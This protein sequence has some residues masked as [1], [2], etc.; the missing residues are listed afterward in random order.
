MADDYK[1][2]IGAEV[3]ES[4]FQAVEARVANLTQQKRTIPLVIDPQ[5][6][7]ELGQIKSALDTIGK[8]SA[9]LNLGLN[10]NEIA[11]AKKGIVG[12]GNSIEDIAKASKLL[13]DA[14]TINSFVEAL[15][16]LSKGSQIGTEIK[17]LTTEFEKIRVAI[18]NTQSAISTLGANGSLQGMA[19]A[20]NNVSDSLR[21][22][23]TD[24]NIVKTTMQNLSGSD[25]SNFAS[26]L[27]QVD[28]ETRALGEHESHIRE[29][30]DGI[31][32][33]KN[34]IDTVVNGLK[35]LN[36]EIEKITTKTQGNHRFAIT[37]D[38][39][40]KDGTKVQKTINYRQTYDRKNKAYTN[41]WVP[42]ES[43]KTVQSFGVKTKTVNESKKA[44]SDILHALS[45]IGRIRVELVS[46]TDPQR[47]EELT[48]D[49]KKYRA[50][51][52]DIWKMVDAKNLFGDEEEKQ[53]SRAA[54]STADKIN[55]ANAKKRT[56]E[57]GQA[58]AVRESINLWQ[59]DADDAS[60]TQKASQV[61]A[62]T[63]I[64]AKAIE[65]YRVALENLRAVKDNANLNDQQVIETQNAY[66]NALEKVNNVLS[67]QINLEKA[68]KPSEKSS[69]EQRRLKISKDNFESGMNLW[70]SKNS[71]AAEYY[72]AEIQVIREELK[73]CDSSLELAEVNS[74]FTSLK[75]KAQEAG[76]T[77]RSFGESLKD[78]GKKFV[79]AFSLERIVD[80]AISKL[81]EMYTQVVEIDSALTDFY[82]VTDEIPSA[83]EAYLKNAKKDAHELGRTV[84]SYIT[85][86]ATWAQRGYSMSESESLAKVS[87][88]YANVGDV[89]DST[90]VGDLTA[91][92][93]AFNIEASNAIGI[94]DVL[95]EVSNNFAVSAADL[96]TG[97]S[98]SASTMKTANTSFEQTAAL[99]TGISE[100]TQSPS[101]AGNFLRTA[102]MRIRGMKGELE[103]LGETVD[104]DVDSI[105]KVQT[106]ILNLTGGKVNI[107]DDSGN[108][109]NYYDIMR[110]IAEVYNSL[111]ATNQASLSEI[112]FG[113][114]RSN[115]GAALIQ[116]FQSGQ[117]DKAYETALQSEGSAYAEQ[118]K[119]AESLQYR[120]DK[121]ASSWQALSD[122]FLDSGML[123]TALDLI[124]GIL[125]CVNGIISGVGTLPATLTTIAGILA[126]KGVGERIK[127]FHDPITLGNEYA[128]KTFY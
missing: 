88:I 67:A 22:I 64:I 35:Q 121:I 116:A 4:E 43:E 119:Y 54:E 61:K 96:G 44:L 69:A 106:Q 5:T 113:K 48:Q 62:T 13:G 89:D 73:K 60:V 17:S 72:A 79:A 117:I 127:Q 16:N 85:Q 99:L 42:E 33:G 3:K 87:S 46:E 38:G 118:E 104:D 102:S 110:E 57:A 80:F 90:A 56:Q 97:F 29:S 93:K 12:L 49:L 23:V 47:I 66:A 40:D 21:Q 125:Q 26:R 14:N 98:N 108:F 123:K 58:N 77:V 41:N 52:V 59:L 1:V 91:V 36:L 101:E 128:H 109:R 82:K 68:Q 10:T 50:E 112:L 7:K 78:L 126:F 15:S 105:S 71:E 103:E 63:D 120:I 11:L 94:V 39:I 65:E 74:A 19:D 28:A 107:F 75:R 122:T 100:I 55:K 18:G 32:I 83:Y 9:A 8:K 30:L 81:K 111:S 6:V 114:Q 2:I 27:R 53:A 95:N 115:Q 51:L 24:C 25:V 86:T 20:F 31:G 124:D 92:M 84:S 34:D 45:E 37:V 76:K 70:L